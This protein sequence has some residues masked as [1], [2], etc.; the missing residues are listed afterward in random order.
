MAERFFSR[1]K[2]PKALPLRHGLNGPNPLQGAALA[3]VAQMRGRSL[4]GICPAVSRQLF[5][6]LPIKCGT[7]VLYM[8][9]SERG[10][11]GVATAG[12]WMAGRG[13]AMACGSVW[14]G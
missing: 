10:R 7:I 14:G 13:R 4:F 11:G 1:R 8:R 12:C 3:V 9:K 2:A 6:L 5:G